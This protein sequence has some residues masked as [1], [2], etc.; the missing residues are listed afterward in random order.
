M[1]AIP[2]SQKIPKIYTCEFCDYNTSNKKDFDKHE[3]TQ[4]HQNTVLAMV[5]N[6]FSMKNPQK[7]PK[8]YVCCCCN[9]AYKDNSGLWKHKKKCIQPAN[10][11]GEIA[12]LTT[13]MADLMKSNQ[14]LQQQM[15][16]LYKN[17]PVNTI[18]NN[19]NC[20]NKSF[21]LQVFLNETCK[22]AMNMKDFVDSIQ[23]TL[24]DVESMGKLGYVNGL[25]NIIIKNLKAIDYRLRPVHC[26]DTKRDTMY[27][28]TQNAWIKEDENFTNIR[29]FIQLV[30]NKNTK[31]VNLFRTK[32]PDCDDYHSKY[33]DQFN[34]IIMESF[35]NS[36]Y[37][38]ETKI[39]KKIAKEISID[40]N[41]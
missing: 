40:K 25:S 13:I 17:G 31:S 15:I 38:N 36:D 26:T 8:K 30:A 16:D 34:K 28:K 21:N 20:N 37:D 12:S 7:S 11:E 19:T 22:D 39:I 9:R 4:K 5:G 3:T 33:N 23:I 32:Y 41:E 27:T 2:K 10:A 18:T 6:D 24:A 1:L 29:K 14:E 35:V